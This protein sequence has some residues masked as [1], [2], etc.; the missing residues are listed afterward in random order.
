[1]Q[2]IVT[3][4]ALADSLVRLEDEREFYSCYPWC[5]NA[6][7]RVGDAIRFLREE[8]KRVGTVFKDWRIREVVTN[9]YLLACAVADSTDDFILGTRFDFSMAAGM[10]P[11]AG[12]ALRP[13]EKAIGAMSSVRN[14]RLKPARK[15][16]HEW[17]WVLELFSNLL[18]E[19]PS[20]Q[21]EGVA[22]GS[23]RLDSL[24]SAKI[25]AELEKQRCRIPAAFRS[26][27]LTHWDQF[28]LADRLA[29]ELPDKTK[30]L[31]IL[32]CRT[33]GSYF[34]PLIQ[35]RLKRAGF[36][37]VDCVTIRP[38]RGLSV[39][40]RS[41]LARIAGKSGIAVIVDEP[42]NTGSTLLKTVSLLRKSGIEGRNVMVLAPVH[43]SRR[44]WNSG[45]EMAA[46][47]KMK[48]ITLEPEQWYKHQFLTLE[49]V[50]AALRGYF[51]RN[52]MTIDSIEEA[53]E[54][55]AEL[56]A[57]SEL[58][59]HNRLKKV[60][61]VVATTG[62]GA[63]QSRYIFAKSVGWGWLSYH[64][65]L[66]GDRMPEQVQPVL[67]LR[68][69][70]LFTEWLPQ[71]RSEAL[72]PE[73]S[74]RVAEY[75]AARTHHLRLCEDPTPDLAAQGEHKGMSE[76]AGIL[77]KA[78]GWKGASVLKRGRIL[79]ELRSQV[80]PVPTLIDG[81]MRPREWIGTNASIRKADFEHHGQGK[82]ELSVTDPAYD[83][84]ETVLQ[85]KLAAD[86]EQALLK[87]YVE[88]SGDSG[89]H[90]RL[91]LYKLLAGS[92]A[93]DRALDNLNDPRLRHRHAEF[94][95]DYTGAFDFLTEQIARHCAGFCASPRELRWAGPLLVLDVDG[96]LDKQIFGFPSTTASGVLA[97]SMLHGHGISVMLNSARSMRQL[98]LYC[99]AFGCV[100]G[101]AEYGSLIWD[102][103]SGQQRVLVGDAALEQL[104]QLK[105]ALGTIPGVFVNE[106]Y[107]CLI[108]AYIY[109]RG[110][111]V[112]LPAAIIKGL[113]ARLNTH[114]LELH[115]TYTDS[116]IVAKE[117]NKG[118]GLTELL[119]LSG[120][121]EIETIAVGDSAPDLAMFRVATRS[122]GP[123]N[124]SCRR[125]AE[126]LGCRVAS[127]AYQPGLLE[128]VHRIVHGGKEA[129]SC[130][131]CR[132]ATPALYSQKDLFSR[133]LVLADQSRLSLTLK[134]MLD[135]LA[136]LTFRQ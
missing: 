123:N 113:M 62:E 105:Q 66:C 11:L 19:S 87:K 40:E 41:K 108:K 8:L 2:Q 22:K 46:L 136:V 6:Y 71:A 50:D 104:S 116:T 120:Q 122:F 17:D 91:V 59:F 79:E 47:S 114:L 93:M 76:L 36:Q 82:T 7:P 110:V 55:N 13:L 3:R 42:I 61:K 89:V 124:I 65:F 126:A 92:W 78:Y 101:V 131:A 86:Q 12:L 117:I 111:T 63:I 132:E 135:P 53:S 5:V 103:L 83:L 84:A 14:A 102:R 128:I 58:K 115:Q 51:A 24:L 57:V 69:G 28:T 109:D 56:A 70:V 30:P 119:A 9:A 127:K 44:D 4:N 74:T 35:S 64:A 94:N 32:G 72:A 107:Q 31:L 112:P 97:M 20:A 80:C 49:G 73:I 33:A 43:A 27:D 98:K 60:Y 99:E 38:K 133:L 90:T 130:A 10:V 54:L 16:R 21:R 118:R 39:R 77:S 96:V 15:W 106:D 81:K 52:G 23:A 26:Q 134:A 25:P 29:E 67:G 85:W 125:A 1:M 34:A 121:T 37:D 75:V 100:G 129:K 95:R 68:D 88:L 18:Q 45:P 48:V